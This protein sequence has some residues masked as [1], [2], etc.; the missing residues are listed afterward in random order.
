[1]ME[2]PA[3]IIEIRPEGMLLS[4]Q[5]EK[6]CKACAT[7][8]ACHG[9]EKTMSLSLQPGFKPGDELILSLEDDTFRLAA[10][11]AYL[12]PV[13]GLLAGSL[14]GEGVGHTDSLALCGA[15]VGLPIGLLLARLIAHLFQGRLLQPEIQACP[16]P[17]TS[18]NREP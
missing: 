5:Q 8:E 13:I 17:P 2:R 6:A 16:Q 7:R 18:R 12:V 3:R 14:I 10:V 4:V 15:A 1:M 9:K 11:L